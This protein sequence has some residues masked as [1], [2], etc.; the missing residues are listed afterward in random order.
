MKIKLFNIIFKNGLVISF[1]NYDI[2]NMLQDYFPKLFWSIHG[3]IGALAYSLDALINGLIV[4]AAWIILYK[5]AR[6]IAMKVIF[7]TVYSLSFIWYHVKRLTKIGVLT[8]FYPLY[9]LKQKI[10]RK[11]Y[12]LNFH[13]YLY[14]R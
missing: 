7:I 10:L 1:I 5:S 6:F 2:K 9:I 8:L 12:I 3:E 13:A 11:S 4:I 14:Y